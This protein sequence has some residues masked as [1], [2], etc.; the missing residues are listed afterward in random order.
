MKKKETNYCIMCPMCGCTGI[1]HTVTT[2]LNATPTTYKCRH[3]KGLGWLPVFEIVKE[4]KYEDKTCPKCKSIMKPTGVMSYGCVSCMIYKCV[5]C[6][7]E[8]F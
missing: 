4:E 7:K 3:C 1:S 8:Y 6:G 2:S 5:E